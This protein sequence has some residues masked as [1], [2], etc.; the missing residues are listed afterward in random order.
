M[1]EKKQFRGMD[2]L[3]C[4]S[5]PVSAVLF[6]LN[7]ALV[8]GRWV[9]FAEVG[10]FVALGSLLALPLW[11]VLHVIFHHGRT[12]T[13]A[14]WLE[15]GLAGVWLAFGAYS[16]LVTFARGTTSSLIAGLIG[17]ALALTPYTVRFLRSSASRAATGRTRV[18]Q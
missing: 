1:T 4:S 2:L 17:A 3:I 6:V 15:S 8:H 11:V 16:L 14:L 7:A 12:A 9:R 10:L 5:F 18:T 13:W